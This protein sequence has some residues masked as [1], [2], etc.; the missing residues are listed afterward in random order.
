ME[1]LRGGSKSATT[2]ERKYSRRRTVIY[3]SEDRDRISFAA[4][5]K[6]DLISTFCE[7][8]RSLH[9]SPPAEF[10]YPSLRRFLGFADRNILSLNVPSLHVD[11]SLVLIDERKD[12][13]NLG[14][15]RPMKSWEAPSRGQVFNS[16]R[17]DLRDL[18]QILSEEVMSLHMRAFRFS[19]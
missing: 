5:D 2:W 10:W 4:G 8:R 3:D 1:L 19:D 9:I 11:R 6:E 18:L 14:Q 7:A 15:E 17:V 13:D 12:T 16:R